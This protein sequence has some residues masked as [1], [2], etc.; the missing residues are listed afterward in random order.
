MTTAESAGIVRIGAYGVCLDAERRILLCRISEP[1]PDNGRWTLPGGGVEFGESPDA[2]AIREIE[3][4][5]GLRGELASVAGIYSA[6]IQRSVTFAGRPLHHVGI[7]Y[8]LRA[9]QGDLR[10][11]IDGTT[12]TCAWFSAADA[13]QLPLVDLAK[14]GLE[15]AFGRPG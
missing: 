4:E 8:W 1:T 13:R 9:Y 6:M 10:G 15:L 11:E 2:A 5:S 12:D 14:R 7:V 3:E